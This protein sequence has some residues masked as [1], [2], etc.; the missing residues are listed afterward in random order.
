[1]H[2]G[3]LSA[4]SD[5]VFR[6]KHEDNSESCSTHLQKLMANSEGLRNHHSEEI[7]NKIKSYRLKGNFKGNLVHP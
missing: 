6:L 2:G 5:A 7:S 3:H 4:L 1:M